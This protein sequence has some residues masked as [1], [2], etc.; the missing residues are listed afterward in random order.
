MIT[1]AAGLL[2]AIPVLVCFHWISAKTDRLVMDIDQM[3]MT[4][5]DEV[6][7]GSFGAE[8]ASETVAAGPGDGEAAE[9]MPESSVQVATS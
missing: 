7:E 6:V 5:V 3:S 1:T 4:F 8:D 2:V 9:D